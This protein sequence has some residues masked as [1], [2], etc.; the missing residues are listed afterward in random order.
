LADLSWT[1]TLTI[2]HVNDHSA[3]PVEF[4]QAPKTLAWKAIDLSGGA[5]ILYHQINRRN[6]KESERLRKELHQ[7]NE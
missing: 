6:L 2:Q 1:R 4:R 5:S 3:P 7:I